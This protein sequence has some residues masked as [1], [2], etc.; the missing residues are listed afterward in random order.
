MSVAQTVGDVPEKSRDIAT[1]ERDGLIA[2]WQRCFERDPPAR[3]ATVM[4]R[5]ILAFEA[6]CR[7]AGSLSGSNR[8][9]LAAIASGR[10]V[11]DAVPRSTANGT[12][13]VRE[14]NGRLYRVQVVDGGYEMDGVSYR[15]LSA[16]AKKITGTAWSGPRFFGLTAKRAS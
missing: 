15:S 6:Q 11:S 14:W 9:A 8:R 10:G 13:L 4:M 1:L 16:V 12:G 7:A 5:K 3:I 2:E